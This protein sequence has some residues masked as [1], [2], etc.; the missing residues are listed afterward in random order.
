MPSLLI[1]PRPAALGTHL[2]PP[3]Q[4]LVTEND[5]GQVEGDRTPAMGWGYFGPPMFG[6]P[7]AQWL[8]GNI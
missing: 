1:P 6:V 3:T 4:V 7:T 8:F 5:R 2:E